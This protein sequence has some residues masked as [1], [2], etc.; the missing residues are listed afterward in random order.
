MPFVI[1]FANLHTS[2]LDSSNSL[3]S[4]QLGSIY[5]LLLAPVF[6]Y[7]MRNNLNLRH[8]MMAPT[9]KNSL[10]TERVC[11]MERFTRFAN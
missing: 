3:Y 1:A 10:G 8:S 7:F 6:N 11:S 5:C 2:R 4:T 9:P